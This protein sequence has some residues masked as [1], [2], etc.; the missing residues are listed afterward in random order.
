MSQA[1]DRQAFL[2]ASI[3]VLRHEVPEEL[4]WLFENK[5]PA[6]KWNDGTATDP[7]LVKGWLAAA[8]QQQDVVPDAEQ[9]GQ[10]EL[11]DAEDRGALALWLLEAWIAN[12]TQ[13]PAGLTPAREKELR[14]MA[15]R[16]AEMSRKF[17]R[18][19]GDPE[20][21]FQ[22]LLAQEG[23]A[24]PASSLP[25]RG[26]L[27]LVAACGSEVASKIASKVDAYGKSW[28]DRA[29]Q[30]AVLQKMQQAI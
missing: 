20:E 14:A 28:P 30:I 26:L 16:A 25:H 4:E 2:D 19:G 23:N 3:E 27:S 18:P 22:Q 11:L 5:P 12:D 8:G 13:S 6:V 10:A 17:G 7:R 15:E 9:K 29:E 24:A 1:A 21:R